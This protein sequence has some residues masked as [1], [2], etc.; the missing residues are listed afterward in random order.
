[1]PNRMKNSGD[2]STRITGT[3][4]RPLLIDEFRTA[5]PDDVPVM[6]NLLRRFPRLDPSNRA[7]EL[8]DDRY[9]VKGVD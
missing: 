3:C 9:L 8:L 1:L 7:E 6:A 2:G 4:C 5:G